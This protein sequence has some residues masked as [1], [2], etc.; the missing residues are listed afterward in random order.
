LYELYEQGGDGNIFIKSKRG[1]TMTLKW[2]SFYAVMNSPS[3]CIIGI[4]I[5]VLSVHTGFMSAAEEH[6]VWTE[7][8]CESEYAIGDSV[9]VFYKT[10]EGVLFE[11]WMYNSV[12]TETLLTSGT[13]DGKTYTIT[14]EVAPPAG[15]LTFVFKMPRDKECSVCM[16]EYGQC[17]VHVEKELCE[18][19]A[20]CYNGIKDC[21]E[22]GVDCGGGCPFKD[23]DK[24]GVA[25]C[26][27]SCPDSACEKVDA[28][29]CEIDTDSD[30]VGDCEDA[31]PQEKGDTL[32]GCP[33]NEENSLWLMVGVI[34]AILG[35]V[36]V[37]V[38]K[39][40]ST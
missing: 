12:M 22:Y 2:T 19:T 37:F 25:D 36:L 24:D 21:N 32:N 27:D 26:M 29:G 8:G 16:K 15:P 6:Y 39:M 34:V 31:C 33:E 17:T 28:K 35:A 7:K 10:E 3:L 38:K 20:H 4:L 5:L 1:C 23:S 18:S 30:G 9:T 11:L 40:L 14:V 13:G